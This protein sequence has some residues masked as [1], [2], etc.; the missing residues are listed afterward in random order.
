VTTL[1]THCEYKNA[2]GTHSFP[3]CQSGRDLLQD[4]DGFFQ[5]M[6]LQ[7]TQTQ[8]YQRHGSNNKQ[9]SESHS[10]LQVA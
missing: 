10:V 6:V 4:T 9:A 5:R 2:A 7:K 8:K 1:T 3:H